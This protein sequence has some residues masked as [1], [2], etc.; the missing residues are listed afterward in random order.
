MEWSFGLKPQNLNNDDIMYLGDLIVSSKPGKIEDHVENRQCVNQMMA[1][2]KKDRK[3]WNRTLRIEDAQQIKKRFCYLIKSI[4]S[5]DYTNFIHHYHY[6]YGGIELMKGIYSDLAPRAIARL[7]LYLIASGL[8]KSQI[9]NC[10]ECSRVFVVKRKPRPDVTHHCSNS[11]SQLP[12]TRRYREKN[13]AKVQAGDR[14]RS[15]RRY[16]QG[17][18]QKPGHAHSNVKS[19]PRKVS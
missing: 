9:Q 1:L 14:D 4:Q 2:I 7:Q 18:R 13:K 3:L 16:Q 15:R 5:D 6:P 10:P 8:E 11:C 19:N 17:V 12:A